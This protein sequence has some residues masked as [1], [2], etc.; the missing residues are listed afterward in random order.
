M[1]DIRWLVSLP[2]TLSEAEVFE[3]VDAW[4]AK[5]ASLPWSN[6][7]DTTTVFRYHGACMKPGSA[8]HNCSGMN[9]DFPRMVG[10]NLF[11]GELSAGESLPHGPFDAPLR[12]AKDRSKLRGDDKS[13]R[14]IIADR[15]FIFHPSPGGSS[16]GFA[17]MGIA[18]WPLIQLRS[19]L[20]DELYER[21]LQSL[22]VRGEGWVA[23]SY[24]ASV[25][26]NGDEE[27]TQALRQHLLNVAALDM[28]LALGFELDVDDQSG[29]WESRDINQLVA[30]FQHGLLGEAQEAE[31]WKLENPDITYHPFLRR[32]DY[33]ALLQG[34]LPAP[35]EALA[36]ELAELLVWTEF[37][38]Q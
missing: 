20:S 8:I 23:Q 3:R 12:G 24:H 21:A 30:A 4:Y 36:S 17:D 5:T 35:P 18:R 16:H 11:V 33:D 37:S 27:F 13:W 28:A 22:P 32:D 15:A 14:T 29:Y 2:G 26:P 1:I 6:Y 19:E 9:D 38:A 31:R 7:P 25:A 10:R 34:E